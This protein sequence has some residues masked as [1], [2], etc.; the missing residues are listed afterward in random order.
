VEEEDQGCRPLPT[1]VVEQHHRPRA[2]EQHR[3][4]GDE[5]LPPCWE[6][7]E[8]EANKGMWRGWTVTVGSQSRP[9]EGEEEVMG[10]E[11]C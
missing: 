9:G 7:R 10:V 4:K 6:G 8:G 1:W 11:K 3:R 2:E 5:T